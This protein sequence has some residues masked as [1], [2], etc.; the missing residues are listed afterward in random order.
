MESNLSGNEDI[1]WNGSYI[2]NDHVVVVLLDEVVG[3]CE[4]A[5]EDEEGIFVLG[6]DG[7]KLL[8][9]LIQIVFV[10]DE[11]AQGNRGV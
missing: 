11:V 7:V 8:P 9:E 2:F 10:V 6:V 5:S 1:K 3:W 4:F